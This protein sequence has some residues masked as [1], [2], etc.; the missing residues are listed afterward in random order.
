MLKKSIIELELYL[1]FIWHSKFT[2]A[3]A[4]FILQSQADIQSL[5]LKKT[6]DS[7]S[8]DRRRGIKEEDDH[9]ETE[10]FASK[11]MGF[12]QWSQWNSNSETKNK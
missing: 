3:I 11:I 1:S 5:T 10:E 8:L 2:F 12:R 4:N 6:F 7:I 9:M